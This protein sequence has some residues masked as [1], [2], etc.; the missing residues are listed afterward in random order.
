MMYSA[1]KL[2]KQGDNIQL[3]HTPFLIWNQSIVPCPVLTCFLTC[4]Q[5]SQ[6]AGKVVWYSHVFKNFLQFV[7]IHTVKGFSIVNKAEVCVFLELSGTFWNWFWFWPSGDVHVLSHLLYCWKRMLAMTNVFS[8]Q[9]SVSLFLTSFC[10]LK[11]N[12]LVCLGNCWLPT[13]AFMSPMMNILFW[14]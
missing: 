13:F 9:Y 3:W 1:Y 10:T 2:N 8:W 11:P 14:C 4:I 6:E 5:I 12:L 7:V